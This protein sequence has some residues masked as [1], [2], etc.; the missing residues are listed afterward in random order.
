MAGDERKSWSHESTHQDD[1]LIT[2]HRSLV[3]RNCLGALG[4]GAI[5]VAFCLLLLWHDPLIFWNDDYE[6]SILPVFSDVARSWNEGHWPLLS[7][8]SWVCGNLAGEFQYG[9]FSLFVNAAVILI[10][11]FPLTFPQQAAALSS[12][13]LFVLAA[14]AFILARE[15]KCNAPLSIFVALVV[16]LNGWIICWGAT[17]WF[18]ALGAFTWLPWCWWAMEKSLRFST[19][20]TQRST[21]NTELRKLSVGRLMPVLLGPLDVGRFPPALWPVPFVYLLV[22]GGFPYTVLMLVLLIAWLSV[23]SIVETKR[24][25]TVMPMLFGAAL[26]FGISSPAW[27]A[28]LDYVRGSARELQPAAAHWQWI[29]PW[30]ALPAIILPCWTVNW[31]D[32]STRYLPH[33]ATE[34]ACGLVAPA[35]LIAGFLWRP[36]LLLSRLRWE[37][38][39]LA[40]VLGLC[41]A[42]SAGVFRWSF[43]WLPFF[44]LI[45]AICAAEVLRRRPGSP[46]GSASVLLLLA[47]TIPMALLGIGGQYG[48]TVT[49][50]YFQIAVI[51]VLTEWFL[52]DFKFR[53]WAP[54]VATFAILLATYCSIPP[55]CGVPKYNFSQDLIKAEPLDQRHLYLAVYSPAEYAYRREY[56]NGP[57]GKV[58]RPGSTP[59]WAQLR[60]INGYSPI[61]SAGVAR[62]F[63]F[64]IHGEIDGDVG[65]YL[66]EKQS[67]P[68]GLL[69]QLGVD[70]IV[71]AREINSEPAPADWRLEFSSEDGRV[72]HRLG[73]PLPSVRSVTAIDSRPNQEFSS[74]TVSGI[75]DQRNSIEF[76]IN[77]PEGEKPSLVTI[78]RPYFVGYRA[79]LGD[80]NLP[81]DSYR[82]LF[83]IVE[84]PAG[85]HGRV[86]LSYRP[87]W[88]VIGTVCS[89]ACVI[90]CLV[91]VIVGRGG[92]P[93]RPRAIGS[94]APT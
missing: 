3:R 11:K 13:H 2:D 18:G 76:E 30:R 74:A 60:F 33:T 79:H 66:I 93:N 75:R 36:R 24:V 35:A 67:G 61:L 29:V 94:I 73:D 64:F 14:G 89:I 25:T 68:G 77:V 37:L 39:L 1:P 72:Y 63:K 19:L 84:V 56:R 81:V 51:W 82:G 80:K 57:V 44:H 91:L 83:P 86:I 27:L 65:R 52:P 5:V 38:L 58:A 59:M 9:T 28:L 69:E 43:R 48:A 53:E 46:T 50:I 40:I 20:N 54:A 62:Q 87:S 10:W 21:L 32:F 17:D 7:P 31:A 49:W 55:N 4:A 92:S 15:R 22:T 8:Y 88:L 26:G 16:A 85:A 23:K 78:S 41:L 90:L 34:L 42:P 6:L 70:G 47:V 12:I 45:L 71:I